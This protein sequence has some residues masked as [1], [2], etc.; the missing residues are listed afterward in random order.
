[1]SQ[2]PPKESWRVNACWVEVK[3][4][5]TSEYKSGNFDPV[6]ETLFGSRKPFRFLLADSEDTEAD[7]RHLVRFYIEFSDVDTK[8]QMSNVTRS[9]LN[10]EVIEAKPNVK[11]YRR[12]A[13]LELARHCALPTCNFDQKA[14][15]NLVDRLVATIAGSGITVEVVACGDPAA[16]ADIQRYIYGKTHR[17]GGFS[18]AFTDHAVDL[19]GGFAGQPDV[20]R[21]RSQ[22]QGQ[23]QYKSDL[24]VKNVLKNAEAKMNT[25]LFTCSIRLYCDSAE[26]IQ[27]VKDVLPS[28]LNRFKVF[29]TAKEPAKPQAKLKKPSRF[30]VRNILLCRLWWG[31]PAAILLLTGVQGT[32][33]PLRLVASA[34]LLNMDSLI[35]VVAVA[36]M[37]PLYLLFR[38]RN[39]IVL[40]L[41]ELGEIAAMPTAIGKLPV[42]LGQVPTSRMQLGTGKKGEADSSF[43]LAGEPEEKHVEISREVQVVHCPFC[44]ARN[45]AQEQHC[46]NCGAP[47]C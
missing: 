42:S 23:Q 20:K 29:K 46:S 43:T 33:N 17:S 6:L 27:A 19:L 40:S 18:K 9:L 31:I 11:V 21:S 25:S 45:N 26:K 35:F 30:L 4:L 37:L 13:D 24:Y 44:G 15:V 3:P 12:C 2:T 22:E 41:D 47:L 1:M 39:P 5:I 28:A 7:E 36:S 34:N 32:F 14:D 10:A 8:K 16:A 38:R